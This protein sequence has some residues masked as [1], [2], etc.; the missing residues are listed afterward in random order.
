[1]TTF[2]LYLG[3]FVLA[4]YFNSHCEGDGHGDHAC[5]AA[6]FMA[7]SYALVLFNIHNVVGDLE[8]SFDH[9][10]VDDIHFCIREHLSRLH[11]GLPGEWDIA[12]VWTCLLY[13]NY[14]FHY[15]V[16]CAVCLCD[17][18]DLS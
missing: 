4:P 3:C 2:F 11:H 9:V 14:S 8:S 12:R 10:G 1:M 16:V 7:I 17:T 6:Y 18:R 13:A 5:S 15:N